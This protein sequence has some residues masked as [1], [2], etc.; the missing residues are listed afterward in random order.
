MSGQNA[1]FD[2]KHF[3]AFVE[4]R[5]QR[6]PVH[7]ARCADRDD[8]GTALV[9]APVVAEG[10]IDALADDLQDDPPVGLVGGVDDALAAVDAGRELACRLAQS[11]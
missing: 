11:L 3:P 2:P 7:P 5:L 6:E 9:A 1:V 4:G 8:A 10:D